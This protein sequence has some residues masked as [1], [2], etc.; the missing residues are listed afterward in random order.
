[1]SRKPTPDPESDSIAKLIAKGTIEAAVELQ[2]LA[3][4][5]DKHVSKEAR[6]GLYRLKLAGIEAPPADAAS[7]PNSQQ[8]IVSGH[9]YATSLDGNGRRLILIVREDPHGG[10]PI[11][12]S[13]LTSDS[14]GVLDL[15][16]SR[17]SRKQVEQ[18]IA[19]LESRK[20]S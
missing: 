11:L 12:I 15:G 10:S 6:R 2:T 13:F 9:A 8:L 4:S 17:M 20:D 1:M 14:A 3:A 16:G 18:K 5:N 19:S 7:A